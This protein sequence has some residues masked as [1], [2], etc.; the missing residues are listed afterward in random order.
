MT[1]SAE[2]TQNLVQIFL[3]CVGRYGARKAL[4]YK[5]PDKTRYCAWTWNDWRSRVESVAMGLEYLGVSS[6]D[7]VGI[8]SENRP[9][10][11]F[12]DFG[13]LSLGAVTVP[14]YPTSS[15]ED[16]AYIIEHAG[17]RVLFVS[18]TEQLTRLQPLLRDSPCLRQIILFDTLSSTVSGVIVL[19]A[20]MEQ[21]QGILMNNAD[22]FL[23]RVRGVRS[24]DLATII[25]TSGTTGRPKGVMLTH[26]NFIENYLGAKSRIR[27][28]E[29]DLALSF[30]PLS[31]VF[32]RLAGYYF[33]AFCGATIA[34]AESMLTVPDDLRMVRP[35]VAASVPR[36]YEKMY[37]RILETIEASPWLIKR[38]SSWALRIGKRVA[39][40]KFKGEGL[41]PGL[42]VAFVLARTLVL[43]KLKARL[44]GRIRFF[45]SGG[46]PLA[47]ELGEFFYAAG[48]LILEGY[49]LTETSPVITVNSVEEFRFG[50]VGKRLPNVDVKIADDGEILTKG[51]CV[52]KGYYKNEDKTS[53]V[54]RDGWFYTGDVGAIDEAGFLRITD[55]KKDII[56]TSGGK[57]IAP[58]N[59]ENLILGDGLFSQ[60]V[61]AGDKRNYLIALVWLNE[62]ALRAQVQDRCLASLGI[63]ELLKHPDVEKLVD[64]HLRA[65]TQSLP[66][67]E[68]I[69]YFA[70]VPEELSLTAGDLTPT[71]KVKRKVVS[72]KYHLLIEGLYQKGDDYQRGKV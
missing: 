60:V 3:D 66:R 42:V 56:V 13:I 20:L 67:Y 59:V 72:E 43:K 33:M 38:I 45:I 25:Y 4:L 28:S 53:C 29:D 57:N 46:A 23:Q 50:T 62:A 48:V 64:E 71:L 51:P 14:I 63:G 30:L 21:G 41:S 36:L 34:Y 49:G 26:R 35:T 68:Q 17:I 11:T 70:I 55:R 12:A 31:H 15:Y 69:K 24:D 16:A 19:E 10:W 37:G 61:V 47:K 8:L 39:D 27:V 1:T 54:L 65:R 40:A 2:A 44:G 58:Q 18:T 9:E 7:R 6:E 52:M 5:N 32:E 22:L